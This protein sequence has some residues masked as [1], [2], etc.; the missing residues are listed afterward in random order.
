V[1]LAVGWT[2]ARFSKKIRMPLNF[3]LAAAAVKVLPA[4]SEVKVTPLLTGV[5]DPV[6][7]NKRWLEVRAALETSEDG[8]ERPWVK[9]GLDRLLDDL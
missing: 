6:E 1:E 7:S 3:A 5:V 4:L 2:A 8:V 9:T